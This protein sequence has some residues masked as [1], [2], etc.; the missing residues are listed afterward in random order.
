MFRFCLPQTSSGDVVGRKRYD[1][2]LGCRARVGEKLMTLHD[3]SNCC[4]NATVSTTS[5]FLIL[6]RARAHE[7]GPFGRLR[8]THI[9]KFLTL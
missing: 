1:R 2:V 9:L 6:F 8:F 7:K 3:E 5:L 4:R